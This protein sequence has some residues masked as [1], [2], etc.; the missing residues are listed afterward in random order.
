M[1]GKVAIVTG[2]TSGLGR[3]VS[4]TFAGE[5]TNVVVVG[6]S[7]ERGN[8]VVGECQ[9]RGVAKKSDPACFEEKPAYIPVIYSFDP[10]IKIS[11][12]QYKLKDKNRVVIN[13]ETNKSFN[14][15][16]GQFTT[17][18]RFYFWADS[19]QMPVTDM[20][21]DWGDGSI[22]GASESMY[23]NH[24]PRCA[25][26]SGNAGKKADVCKDW[27]IVCDKK[28][29]VSECPTGTG[30]CSA[31]VAIFGNTDNACAQAYFEVMHTYV[32][33]KAVC[34]YKPK[35]TIT[36]NWGAKSAEATYGGSITLKPQ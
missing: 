1:K 14:I 21:I 30:P 3:V 26:D 27:N 22:S 18:M 28:S 9:A 13:N 10:S 25:D 2:A 16:A 5:G 29:K 7:E 20:R 34:S 4:Y 32:C 12:R 17:T 15:D 19:R 35:V 33:N 8:K 6:R 24:K 36:D 11:N 23:K 31:N